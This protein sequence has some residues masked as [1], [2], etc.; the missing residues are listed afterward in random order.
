ML[1]RGPNRAVDSVPILI[2]LKAGTEGQ[3]NPSDALRQA[4]DYIK[5]FRPNKMRIL[6]NADNAIAVRLNLD[7]GDHFVE[8]V[9]KMYSK[10]EAK[11][12]CSES[13]SD[14]LAFSELT[15]KIIRDLK[16]KKDLTGEEKEDLISKAV[17]EI[18]KGI[19]I[20]ADSTIGSKTYV[21][22]EDTFK[23][24]EPINGEITKEER[25]E[26]EIV[27]L[28]CQ[29][30]NVQLLEMIC[31]KEKKDAKGINTIDVQYKWNGTFTGYSKLIDL[32]QYVIDNRCSPE[33]ALCIAEK[34]YGGAHVLCNGEQYL[35]SNHAKGIFGYPGSIVKE[36]LKKAIKLGY[37]DTVSVM[38]SGDIYHC[39]RLMKWEVFQGKQ[40]FREAYDIIKE[41][42]AD[43]IS[44]WVEDKQFCKDSVQNLLDQGI[45]T[46]IKKMGKEDLILQL[47]YLGEKVVNKACI[48]KEN[49]MKELK[50][51]GKEKGEV[52]LRPT[53]VGALISTL[54]FKHQDK[55]MKVV[56][57][58]S[59]TLKT[60]KEEK[61]EKRKELQELNKKVN[62]K[63]S[64]NNTALGLIESLNSG[65]HASN[66]WFFREVLARVVNENLDKLKAV[67]AAICK[68]PMEELLKGEEVHENVIDVLQFFG[69]GKDFLL[70]KSIPGNSDDALVRNSQSV[71]ETVSNRSEKSISSS[72]RQSSADHDPQSST[73]PISQGGKSIPSAASKKSCSA[74]NLPSSRVAEK[75]NE[76]AMQNNCVQGGNFCYSINVGQGSYYPNIQNDFI[77]G[78]MHRSN[79]WEDVLVGGSRRKIRKSSDGKVPKIIYFKDAHYE[80]YRKELLRRILDYNQLIDSIV[81]PEEGSN[82]KMGDLSL[83]SSLDTSSI[84]MDQSNISMDQS[85]FDDV[86]QDYVRGVEMLKE[87]QESGGKDKI[88]EAAKQQLPHAMYAYS[89]IK[90]KEVMEGSTTNQ[91][92]LI[93]EAVKYMNDSGKCFFPLSSFILGMMELYNIETFGSLIQNESK[94]SWKM[95]FANVLLATE[96]GGPGVEAGAFKA[97]GCIGV[98]NPVFFKP[99]EYL[100]IMGEKK[101]IKELGWM[102]QCVKYELARDMISNKENSDTVQYLLQ[103]LSLSGFIDAKFL[104]AVALLSNELTESNKERKVYDLLKSAGPEHQEAKLLLGVL[105]LTQGYGFTKNDHFGCL[106]DYINVTCDGRDLKK[107]RLKEKISIF[108]AYEYINHCSSFVPYNEQEAIDILEKNGY[109]SELKKLEEMI[110][111]HK[112]LSRNVLPDVVKVLK[113]VYSTFRREDNDELYIQQLLSA[114]RE[115]YKKLKV[116]KVTIQQSEAISHVLQQLNDIS[117]IKRRGL[118]LLQ[119]LCD[120][121]EE[122]VS[123]K[124]DNALQKEILPLLENLSEMC[125]KLQTRLPSSF[126]SINATKPVD[127][128][129]STATTVPNR[130]ESMSDVFVY[131]STL[132]SEVRRF[133]SPRTT[134]TSPELPFVVRAQSTQLDLRTVLPGDDDVFASCELPFIVKC[135]YGTLDDHEFLNDIFN[136]AVDH[137]EKREYDKALPLYYQVLEKR[138]GWLKCDDFNVIMVYHNI[139]L[140]LYGLNKSDKALEVFREMLRELGCN[141]CYSK[142]V[143]HNI[144]VILNQE[145][146]RSFMQ[147]EGKQEQVRSYFLESVSNRF[148]DTSTVDNGKGSYGSSSSASGFDSGFSTFSDR[149]SISKRDEIAKSGSKL[150]SLSTRTGQKQSSDSSKQNVPEVTESGKSSIREALCWNE[151]TSESSQLFSR[152]RL[153]S[154]E[155][156]A[157]GM[158]SSCLSTSMDNLQTEKHAASS[159]SIGKR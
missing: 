3:V 83:D 88:Y 70:E 113:N 16:E 82:K 60:I 31:Q 20:L 120:T 86:I 80:R 109:A 118:L 111:E 90:F 127:R 102:L 108:V 74:S 1:V 133:S 124:L 81:I 95:H 153:V 14:E 45:E 12:G 34:M 84:S 67:C 156:S 7:N 97:L 89:I 73:V 121:L 68:E 35:N 141:S 152:S 155:L 135:T 17:S 28:V 146:K 33:I 147:P 11:E 145:D 130:S 125:T 119:Q 112:T 49:L 136:L 96:G 128:Q 117:S 101:A 66:G 52:R 55:T 159:G 126:S 50:E 144:K 21:D 2:E 93:K 71:V 40:E 77:G 41:T 114:L 122:E 44:S 143:K 151:S 131:P 138:K 30:G 106:R 99:T 63:E 8:D 57:G 139:A 140:T 78:R 38:L 142:A 132:S 51:R 56:K 61:C 105:P 48:T 87:G 72:S 103:E 26:K 94:K 148:Q 69:V 32:L 79:R 149:Q 64:I 15:R 27:E 18:K 13:Q 157:A 62:S 23:H 104:H 154:G 4:E 6:T 98:S 19:D 53:V 91:Q 9:N 116:S 65:N 22:V 47:E 37:K 24:F 92:E 5:G 76:D 10:K 42:V 115:L 158:H 43:V 123:Q 134:A 85:D 54:F 107:I 129:Y 58:E 39:I 100:S 59:F 25:K 137:C 150:S 110:R 75:N 46:D 36:S 29:K